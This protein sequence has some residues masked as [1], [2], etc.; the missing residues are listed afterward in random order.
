[1]GID[2]AYLNYQADVSGARSKNR[3]SFEIYWGIDKF[4]H[5]LAISSDFTMVFDYVCDIEIHHPD[6]FEFFQ[7]KTKN[8]KSYTIGSLTKKDSKKNNSIISTLYQIRHTEYVA[9]H[10]K[11]KLAIVSNLHLAVPGNSKLPNSEF[12]LS[13]LDEKN[14]ESILK[15]IRAEFPDEEIDLSDIFFIN[16]DLNISAYKDTM[17]GRVNSFFIQMFG[18]DPIKPG[19]LL[20]LLAEEAQLK[21]NYEFSITS[22]QEV[23]DKKGLSSDRV[24]LIMGRYAEQ[25]FSIAE[26]CKKYIQDSV[27]NMGKRLKYFS[28]IPDVISRLR[29]DYYWQ[30]LEEKIK[31]DVIAKASDLEAD[32]MFS[33]V[34]QFIE[35]TDVDF[36]V[37][38]S[39]EE[40]ELLSLVVLIKFEEVL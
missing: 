11:S 6:R 25:S 38:F 8:A 26:Q 30:E 7:V 3:F 12:Q 23:L 14:R 35:I 22:R 24:N 37:E 4:L 36:P 28:M 18:E 9:G 17:V 16:S 19:A 27:M 39:L 29:M 40:I 15:A 32:E 10:P 1:M 33:L 2:E 21:A 31:K 20:N 5:E 13:L 34:R